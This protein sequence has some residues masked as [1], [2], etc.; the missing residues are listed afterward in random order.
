MHKRVI[1]ALVEI[2]VPANQK[3]FK[4]ICDAMEVIQKEEWILSCKLTAIYESVARMNNTGYACVER[5]IRHSFK[6][7]YQNI[8][9]I[10]EF[11]KWFGENS[12]TTNGNLIA[13][14]YWKLKGEVENGND[15][16]ETAN[17]EF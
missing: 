8:E 14:L 10:N 1:E 3:G 6:T 2:G 5:C 11:N 4:Y 9:N 12:V 16:K 15:D 13:T 17:A 7:A